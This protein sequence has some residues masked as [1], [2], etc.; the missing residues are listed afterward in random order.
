MDKREAMRLT[1]ITAEY[2]LKYRNLVAKFGSDNDH[3]KFIRDLLERAK[4]RMEEA[5][6]F[7]EDGAIASDRLFSAYNRILAG[8]K[9][10]PRDNYKRG[11]FRS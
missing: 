3:A 11:T 9:L 8:K 2:E 5:G 6:L 10:L 1:V 7:H 4:G